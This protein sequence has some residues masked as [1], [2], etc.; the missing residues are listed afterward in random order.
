MKTAWSLLSIL[1]V[2]LLLGAAGAQAG[3]VYCR[4]SGIRVHDGG[5][6]QENWDV[7][8]SAVRRVQRPD[9]T[10]PTTG[11]NISW[12]SVGAIYRPVEIIQAPRLGSARAVS[13]YRLF[14]QS[15]RTGQDRL[16]ARIHWTS[17]S[18]G[19]LQSAIVHYNINV[20]DR[21]L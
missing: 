18:S 17:P 8:N 6:F 16:T 20:V 2:V 3:D 7:V 9:Q 13:N 14:Y 10:K 19:K 5:E 21:P 1:V 15:A 4:H 11:C 12:R